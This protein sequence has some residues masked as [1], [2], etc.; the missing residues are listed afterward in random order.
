M[1]DD[2]DTYRRYCSAAR[3]NARKYLRPV[4]QELIDTQI[5]PMPSGTAP[6]P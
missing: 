1:L 5:L 6:D 3:T 2:A 4:V